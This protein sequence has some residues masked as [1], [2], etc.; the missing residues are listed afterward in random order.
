[1]TPICCIMPSRSK[2]ARSCV[3]CPSA[4]PSCTI[5]KTVIGLPVPGIPVPRRP[6]RR[7]RMDSA[8]RDA[9]RP[10]GAYRI[11]DREISWF[12]IFR[13][14]TTL[15]SVGSS[16][17][18]MRC[19]SWHRIRPM[20]HSA[21]N[22]AC[23]LVPPQGRYTKMYLAQSFFRKYFC[24]RHNYV[25]AQETGITPES[26]NALQQLHSLLSARIRIV[27]YLP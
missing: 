4:M 10:S 12:N 5:A 16:D 19:C 14:Q 23:Q 13:S 15:S 6:V 2:I 7:H 25:T 1:M 18:R 27:Q 11:S 8:G 17:G 22:E 9:L 20:C 21:C 3:T 24:T 26:I